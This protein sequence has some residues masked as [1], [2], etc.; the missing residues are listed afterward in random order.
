ME[1]RDKLLSG[2]DITTSTGVEIGPLCR[3]AVAKSEGEIIYVDHADTAALRKKYA[4]GPDVNTGEIAEVD[5]VWG[6]Q[7]LQACLKDKK[8][9]Y[10]IASHVIE[11][12]PDMITWLEEIEAVLRP[13]GSLRLVVPDR[14]F[15]FDYLRHESRLC[16]LVNAYVLRARTPLPIAIL[17][18]FISVRR[19]DLQAAWEG[20]LPAE[21]PLVPGHDLN[22]GIG[23]AKDQVANGN[24]HDVHCWVFTPRS[25]ANLFAEAAAE[26]LIRYACK[27][28]YDTEP[29]QLE[30]VAIL[31][32]C[33]DRDRIVNSWQQAVAAVKD[34]N[35]AQQSDSSD[36][37][38]SERSLSDQ[39]RSLNLSLAE[40]EERLRGVE[41]ILAA[42]VNSRSWKLTGPLRSLR[43]AFRSSRRDTCGLR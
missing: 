5:A 34:F 31:E 36:G 35:P 40:T 32:P 3:P 16:D 41:K 9:D 26:G 43:K 29:G 20:T 17:D 23:L 19:V 30:F 37:S 42:V 13:E 21:L 18:H 12:V 6:E 39:I 15:T 10:V 8:V 14:R 11:H 33:A 28:L 1:R 25:F 24:Y 22:G 4:D 2:L 38:P 7:T 27:T